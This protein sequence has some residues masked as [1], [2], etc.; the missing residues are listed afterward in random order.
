MRRNW[1]SRKSPIVNGINVWRKT[2]L[3]EKTFIPFCERL[4]KIEVHKTVWNIKL[5]QNKRVLYALS[6]YSNLITF[7]P[8]SRNVNFKILLTTKQKPQAIWKPISSFQV[9]HIFD[10]SITFSIFENQRQK[11]DMEKIRSKNH[12]HG[13]V[14][15]PR[16]EYV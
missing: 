1:K 7:L 4:I 11:W 8:R 14:W 12:S 9:F 5:Y 3:F 13:Y 6:T 16:K 10:P 15:C 2:I